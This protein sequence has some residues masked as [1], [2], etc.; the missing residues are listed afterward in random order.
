MV[1]SGAGVPGISVD[2]HC[3][4]LRHKLREATKKLKCA[5]ANGGE[6]VI[7]KEI[8]LNVQLDGQPVTIK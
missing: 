7:D 5:T 8:E 3:P 2:K 1:D 6:M 4:Q